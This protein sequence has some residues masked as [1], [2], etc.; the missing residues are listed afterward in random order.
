M[1]AVTAKLTSIQ[2][3]RGIAALLVVLHHVSLRF[4]QRTDG[5]NFLG[6]F[7][8]FGFAGVDLFFVISGLIMMITC[9]QHFGGGVGAASFLWR[10]AT[11]IYPLYWVFTFAQIAAMM[12]FPTGTDRSLSATSV[13]NSLL[14]LP[15]AD[16]PILAQGWTLVYEMFFYLVFAFLFFVPG[17]F[18]H[19]FLIGWSLMVVVA[20]ILAPTAGMT[21]T[22]DL[23]TLSVHASPMTLE[24]I[25]G[26]W[27]GWLYTRKVDRFAKS[28]LAIG[29]MAFLTGWMLVDSYTNLSAEFGLTRVIVFGGASVLVLYGLVAN[30]QVG[31]STRPKRLITN[32]ILVAMG[33][34]S[35]SLYLSHLLV[36]NVFLVIWSRLGVSQPLVQ[37]IYVA[38]MVV[39]CVSFSL[40]TYRF[41][42]RPLLN[43][44]RRAA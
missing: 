44:L 24:F 41:I 34:A 8:H 36:I 5:P 29:T 21:D 20:Y 32:R 12:A 14:L 15:Q 25:A 26:C 16:Y 33:D 28:S 22:N 39:T 9:H 42:E 37:A 40:A 1:P 18:T 30:E 17:R 38:A 7:D 4:E 27:V 43:S 6:I 23:V 3:A 19:H 13:I 11:R 35:Y 10:R 2:S 31:V